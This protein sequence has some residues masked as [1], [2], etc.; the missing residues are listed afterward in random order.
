MSKQRIAFVV[1]R[2]GR[3]V[4]GG[5]EAAAREL[6]ERLAEDADVHVLTTCAV[7][8]TTWANKYP[9]GVSHLNGV[10][11]QRFPVDEARNWSRSQKETGRLL[12]SRRSIEQEM[13][14]IRRNGPFSAALL[15]FVRGAQHEFDLFVFFTYLYATTFFALPLVA[16]KAI[17]VPAAHEEPF[18]YLEAY[19][20]LFHM[21]RHIVYLTRAEQALVQRVMGNEQIPATVAGVG[22]ETQAEVE[23]K[24][25]RRKHGIEGDFLLYS[26]RISES[27]N[28]P[29]LVELFRRYRSAYGAPLK[30]VLT[31]S[32]HISLPDDEDVV[33][34]GFV[35]EQD[36]VD[37][38]AA[39]TV[40]VMPSLY[41]SLS[42]VTL[43]AWAVGTPVLANGRCD[44]LRQQCRR[45]NGGLYY[46]S[47]NEFD[48]ALSRFLSS[49]EL[50]AQLGRQGQAFVRRHYQWPLILS[51]YHEIF[52]TV[53]G[54]GT[55]RPSDEE[56]L[57]FGT[58][59]SSY[60]QKA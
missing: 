48:A 47:S 13:A 44:V 18:L 31:G 50:R 6:A 40:F 14:W 33:R 57:R 41:E 34:L 8:Y 23:P 36:K 29:E 9:A 39:A 38:M 45:S 49:G 52:A 46:V 60:G 54:E 3:E 11:V 51:T 4:N 32:P 22:V 42:I 53:T 12:Q 37:A 27:K 7:D 5:A 15:Q 2:Y 1:Q 16:D 43:E 58:P 20:V 25:F 28:V 59:G 24:R 17:L 26:G 19:R 56:G 35:P 55:V 30:L 10:Q 21:P